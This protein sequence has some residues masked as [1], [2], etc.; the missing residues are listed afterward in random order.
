M[1]IGY[2]VD[3]N[4]PVGHRGRFSIEL[5]GV[6]APTLDLVLPSWVPGSYH[7][8]NYV[9]GFRDVSARTAG[10][11]GPIPVERVSSE[12]WR[13]TT[14]GIHSLT[15]QYSVYGHQMVTEAFDLTTDHLFL[16]AALCLPFVDGHLQ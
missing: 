1:R 2:R 8:V 4:V 10:G 11:T 3:A 6:D 12:R 16:N 13:L 7:L 15:V 14:A 9:R 5:E